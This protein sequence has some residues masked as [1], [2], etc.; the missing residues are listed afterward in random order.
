MSDWYH[1]QHSA[2]NRYDGL[3]QRAAEKHGRMMRARRTG[4]RLFARLPSIPNVGLNI[5][6]LGSLGTRPARVV[7]TFW[8]VPAGAAV[9]I[10]VR[11]IIGG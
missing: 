11:S 3:S 2:R 8:W 5:P 9:L 1:A 10:L 7:K 6:N 4:R